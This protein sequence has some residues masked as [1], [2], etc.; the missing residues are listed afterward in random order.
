MSKRKSASKQRNISDKSLA[1]LKPFSKADPLINRKGRP[2]TLSDLRELIQ[3]MG[4]EPTS[5]PKLTR[6]RLLLRG[7]YAARNASDRRAVLEYGW[8]KVPQDL[9]IG[10]QTTDQLRDS[11]AARLRE[12][13]FDVVTDTGNGDASPPDGG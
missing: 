9:N 4:D 6:L 1:N 2:R 12:I 5:D 7:M 8:G 13:G 3:E 11:I 10:S